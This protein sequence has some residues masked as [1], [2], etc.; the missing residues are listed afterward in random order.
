MGEEDSE[1][2]RGRIEIGPLCPPLHPMFFP[3]DKS[4]DEYLKPE[5]KETL[6]KKED[7]DSPQS[8]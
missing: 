1:S 2:K 6:E 5:H 7:E 4:M 8:T 3:Y